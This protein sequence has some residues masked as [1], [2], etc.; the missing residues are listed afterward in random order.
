MSVVAKDVVITSY[1]HISARYRPGQDLKIRA[2]RKNKRHRG[3][4]ATA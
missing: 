1:S 2:K 4:R 3:D